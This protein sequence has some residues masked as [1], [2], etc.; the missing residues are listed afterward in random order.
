MTSKGLH[1]LNAIVNGYTNA[2]IKPEIAMEAVRR[3]LPVI[4]REEEI[5]ERKRMG[6]FD[7]DDGECTEIVLRIRI[8]IACEEIIAF[9]QRAGSS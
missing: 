2:R 8:E 7:G 5:D 9:T 1:A 4:A 3:L 6:D